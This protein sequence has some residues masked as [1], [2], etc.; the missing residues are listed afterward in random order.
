VE[1]FFMPFIDQNVTDAQSTAADIA[2]NGVKSVTIGDKSAV[3]AT[4][5]E[6][7]EASRLIQNDLDGG[8]FDTVPTKKGYF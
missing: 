3:Y 1:L 7:I 6:Q 2:K 8:I 5:K 4:V